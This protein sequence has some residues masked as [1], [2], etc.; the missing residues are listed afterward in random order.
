MKRT[1]L[2]ILSQSHIIRLGLRQCLTDLNLPVKIF[3]AADLTTATDLYENNDI[4]L[5]IAG[6][7]FSDDPGFHQLVTSGKPEGIFLFSENHLPGNEQNLSLFMTPVELAAKIKMML[8]TGKENENMSTPE[9]ELSKR[10]KEVVRL[11]ALGASNKDIAE[12]LNLSLHTALTHR[13]NII[14]KLGIKTA[15]GLTVFAILNGMITLEEANL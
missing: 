1:G 15:A 3:L 4:Q 7:E 13:K 6:E 12:K 5:I 10:E 9:K 11:L 2:M 14:R 8:Q